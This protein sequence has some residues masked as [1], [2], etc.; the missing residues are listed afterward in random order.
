MYGN[1]KFGLLNT[2]DVLYNSTDKI[3]NYLLF[4]HFSS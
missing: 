4:L 2:R 1:F 3:Q